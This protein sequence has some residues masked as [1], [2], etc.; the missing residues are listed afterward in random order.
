MY[1]HNYNS[2]KVN[3]LTISTVLI[4]KGK[5]SYLI[6]SGKFSSLVGPHCAKATN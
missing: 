5:F 2:I 1:Q 3:K 4:K 6:F